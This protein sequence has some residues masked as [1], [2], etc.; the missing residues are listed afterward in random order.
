[1][2]S[3][4]AAAGSIDAAA[5]ITA[6]TSSS[7]ITVRRCVFV[8]RSRARPA[9]FVLTQPHRTACDEAARSTPCWFLM[10]ASP[11]PLRRSRVCHR[12]TSPIDSRATGS[13]AI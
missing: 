12:S 13:V 5:A 10:P 1:M 3:M 2:R 4:S 7:V 9:T 11:M 8:D 6:R